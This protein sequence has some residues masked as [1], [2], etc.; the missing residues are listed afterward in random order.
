MPQPLIYIRHSARDWLTQRARLESSSPGS[1]AKTRLLPCLR[2]LTGH[3]NS[4]EL[5]CG[6]RKSD[7]K[8]RREVAS[9]YLQLLDTRCIAVRQSQC[10]SRTTH[11]PVLWFH[12]CREQDLINGDT[13]PPVQGHFSSYRFKILTC[14]IQANRG[15]LGL[16]FVVCPSKPRSR[17]A[18]VRS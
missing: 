17:G 6:W 11:S 16:C 2:L 14:D 18:V 4:A 5:C 3:L 15:P 1:P 9:Y 10:R 13:T 7:S 8:L 12:R